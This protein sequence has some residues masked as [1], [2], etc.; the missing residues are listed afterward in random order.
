VVE[1]CD[2]VQ[3]VGE[4]LVANACVAVASLEI[5]RALKACLKP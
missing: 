2:E 1:E 3:S 4:G 5:R